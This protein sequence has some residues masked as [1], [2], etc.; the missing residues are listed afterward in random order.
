MP[1]SL[2]AAPTRW[3]VAVCAVVLVLAAW[4]AYGNTF[5]VPFLLDDT[6]AI[7]ENPS[8]RHP[9]DL[10]QLL[11][12]DAGYGVTVSGRPLLNLS[13]ALCYAA[14]G[15]KVWSYH[16][17]N[18]AIHILAG[19]TLFGIIRRTQLQMQNGGRGAD[20]SAVGASATLLAFAVA[21]IWV[22]HPLQTEAVTYVVQRSE[23]MMGLF[24]LLTL[25]SF[26]R[27]LSTPRAWR[28][29]AL[30][31]LA[32]LCA[33][34]T[35]EVAATAPLLV[36]LYDRTF[37]SGTFAEAWRRRRW[38]HLS[39]AA[40][41]LP[42]A[43]LVASTGWNRGGTAGF[44]VGIR[45]GA[46]WYTQFEAVTRYLHQS[47]WP[48][49]LI[50]EYGTFWSSVREA[51]PFALVVL[52]LVVAVL[53]ALWRWPVAGFLGAWVF[54]ILAP[55]SLVPG[56]IQMIVEHRMYLPLA[57]VVTA[58]VF[59]L[60]ELLRL[61]SRES[62]A[63]ANRS[64]WW[65]TTA[66]SSVLP[67]L[68]LAIP[69]GLMTSQRNEVYRDDLKLW[70]QTVA[71][72]P[73]SALAQSCLGTA[74]Y[75]RHRLTEAMAHYRLAL[76]LD[77]RLALNHYNLGLVYARLGQLQDAIAHDRE[78]VHINPQF[79]PA[80]YQLGLALLQ[81]NQ[82]RDAVFALAEAARLNPTMAEAQY[83]WGVALAELERDNEAVDRYRAALRLKPDFTA[84]ECDLG[85]ALLRLNNVTE[86]IAS[87]QRAIHLDATIAETHFN[88]GL[89]LA[90]LGS[91]RE[92]TVQYAEAVRLDPRNPKAQYNLGLALGQT[93]RLPEAVEHL[94][95]ATELQPSSA[96]AH[97]N[98]AVAFA[99]L[100]R[101]SAAAEEYETT[102]R[103]DPSSAVAHHGLGM[104]LL[105]LHRETEARRQFETALRLKPDFEPARA[106][107]NRFRSAD[108]SN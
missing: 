62:V 19:L 75:Q 3:V 81:L 69:L 25:Y 26:I 4:A 78:T 59:G 53:V 101:V 51:A 30:S 105:Q 50:F 70:Q 29:Q 10:K 6:F 28:W 21:L 80:W 86:A 72:R 23:S 47:I 43:L 107:L 57:A 20:Q 96:E 74:L 18:L 55:T 84:A 97:Q 33:V 66:V 106:M 15:T 40:T 32:C 37:V 73:S 85:A 67:C 52:P 77:P 90:R 68:T 31:V 71:A 44:N 102:V 56:T 17:F 27:S 24:F 11:L 98:L 58:V 108:G 54:I 76:Q 35:K 8:L 99:M 64:I 49:P 92:A 91:I 38:V 41:W 1:P 13:F 93:G 22:L 46:Y 87:L 39:L 79:Y 36:F 103:L 14:S 61:R 2:T 88:L 45:P 104:A 95:A 5:Q 48:H 42:L 82:P 83:E 9:G 63:T 7:A 100:G 65:R 12:P 16:A 89:A 94:L 60:H 34:A